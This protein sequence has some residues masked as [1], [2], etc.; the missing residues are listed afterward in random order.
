M[1]RSLYILWIAF[2]LAGCQEVIEETGGKQGWLSVE[3]LTDKS[4]ETRAGDEA[5]YSLVVE[6]PEGEQVYS[7]EDC[8]SVSERIL[9]NAGVYRVVASSGKDV[10][11]EFESPLYRAEQ[12]IDLQGGQ[13]KQIAL[14]CS[15][16]NVKVTVDYSDAIKRNFEQYS[17]LVENGKGSLLFEKDETRA[18][19][20]RVNEGTLAWNLTLHNGQEEF[21]L[22]K[23]IQEVKAR[24]HYHFTFD[25]RED[26]DA[27]DGALMFGVVV[28]T[29]LDVYNWLCE[30]AL[31]DKFAMPEISRL[32]GG[33]MRE[34]YTVLNEARGADIALHVKAEAGMSNLTVT[35]HSDAVKALGVPE[36]FVLTGM[37]SEVKTAVNAA[38]ITWTPEDVSDKQEANI[39]FSALANRLPL[40]DY[41]FYVSVYD[42][43]CHLVNDTLRIAV[44]PDIDHIADD[45]NVMDVWAKFATIRG[46]WYTLT[47]PEGMALEYSVDR[48]QWMQ[49]TTLSF[50]EET[51]TF[52]ASLTGL[53][54]ATTYYY[55]TTSTESG[56]SE[57]IR[58]FTTERAEQVA[59]MNFDD[60]YKDGKAPVVGISGQ[61]VI[62]DSGN[63]GGASFSIIPTN[64]TS[65]AVSGKAVKMESQ[66][67]VVKF[68]AGNIYTGSY[69]GSD[70]MTDVKL[71]FGTPY[72]C[73]P[74]TLS[75]YFKYTPGTINRTKSPYDGLNGKTDTCAI[76]IALCDWDKP[77]EAR[78]KDLH[79]PN[80]A[81]DPG[82]IAYGSFSTAETVSEYRKFTIKLD[83]RDPSRKPKY[84]VIVASA[85]KYGD[86]FTGS[87]KSVMWIDEFE[88]GFDPVE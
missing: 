4:V 47:R 8:A 86:Y 54:P 32:D 44:I 34:V 3:C 65:D 64:E 22:N 16:A 15:Q 51:K 29:T 81:T 88:L 70:G 84:I 42:A 13:T 78:S 24:Q 26:G 35:H 74:T 43:A 20:L 57:T 36:K 71:N 83:Y 48:S 76:Y 56:A 58:K 11:A 17:L 62:W 27:E 63:K 55:R 39:D 80:Y 79:Y 82:V 12:E 19:Y 73:R 5:C 50:N 60:W 33:K 21:H 52:S 49:A 75:G 7:C 2:L 45:V 67:A 77:F 53:E 85:S 14:I 69:G 87:E 6:N 9:L 72:E 61:P 66:Y 25:I 59:Y 40:G 30:I 38:G 68:A 41:E 37:A 18:G 46:R 10:E 23:T 1:K 31:K 28:D